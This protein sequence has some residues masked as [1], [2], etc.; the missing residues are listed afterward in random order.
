MSIGADVICKLP[1]YLELSDL[2][3][4][5]QVNTVWLRTLLSYLSINRLE[6]QCEC[7]PPVTVLL[8]L[9][10]RCI[11]SIETLTIPFHVRKH[12]ADF[13]AII[14]NR[15]SN[16]VT[17]L[18]VKRISCRKCSIL[19][20]FSQY[21]NLNDY[22]FYKLDNIKNLTIHLCDEALY[23]FINYI[24]TRPL[25]SL[26]RLDIHSINI[27]D[28]VYRHR[29]DEVFF[30]LLQTTT[31]LA[32]VRML[33][34]DFTHK[35]MATFLIKL[36]NTLKNTLEHLIFVHNS[37]NLSEYKKLAATVQKIL[38]QNEPLVSTQLKVLEFVSGG[39][40]NIRDVKK[41]EAELAV[42]APNC[43]IKY[44]NV[45]VKCVTSGSDI[46]AMCTKWKFH[47]SSYDEWV[48][49]N[50]KTEKV[51]KAKTRL[52]PSPRENVIEWLQDVANTAHCVTKT[53]TF[54][55]PKHKHPMTNQIRKLL[56]SSPA[57]YDLSRLTHFKFVN[58]NVYDSLHRKVFKKI[59]F[60]KNGFRVSFAIK[61][62][63]SSVIKGI[64]ILRPEMFPEKESKMVTDAEAYKRIE[65][66]A[67][68]GSVDYEIT[69]SLVSILMRNYS[70]LYRHLLLKTIALDFGR[71][72][73][74]QKGLNTAIYEDMLV[75]A[76]G[77]WH[78][79][80]YANIIRTVCPG[81]RCN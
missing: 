62:D 55:F 73:S 6:I 76:G 44:P 15:N 50:V 30:K 60:P 33:I 22:R 32:T 80:T 13:I 39:P 78:L 69:N 34:S 61:Y 47:S 65:T 18:K 48:K 45:V 11:D 64:D 51:E 40:E 5:M 75:N 3:G 53:L 19:N 46:H 25:I 72:L 74:S 43:I 49:D 38:K 66:L 10:N 24:H 9:F 68:T 20:R 52:Q 36:I 2:V 27:K 4:C 28:D 63:V 8:K 1:R 14:L 77:E 42:V 81:F 79:S 21:A 31:K 16:S 12:L 35:Y 57:T 70:S 23:D 41:L 67:R 56:S 37:M 17:H 29:F 71:F 54:H 58:F 59:V 7:K 26:E